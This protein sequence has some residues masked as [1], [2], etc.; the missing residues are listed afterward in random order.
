MSE[1]ITLQ[2]SQRV[3]RHAAHGGVLLAQNREG[4]L[5]AEGRQQLEERMR[6]YEQGLLILFAACE[7]AKYIL[8]TLW[9]PKTLI[10]YT[11]RIFFSP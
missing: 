11:S 10:L 8:Q 5:D 7:R 6:L 9:T 3:V 1:Q 4:N 2:V